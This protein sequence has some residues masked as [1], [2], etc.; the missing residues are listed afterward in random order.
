MASTSTPHPIDSR[1]VRSASEYYS[2]LNG[3]QDG[4]LGSKFGNIDDAQNFTHYMG[5]LRDAETTNFVLDFGDKDAW[6]ATNLEEK[7]VAKLLARPV[8]VIVITNV[9]TFYAI[10]LRL[11]STVSCRNLLVS[12]LDGCE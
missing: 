11:M 10:Y 6:C 12:G 2:S 4:D 1:T 3:H 7:D 8:R 9:Y 5:L